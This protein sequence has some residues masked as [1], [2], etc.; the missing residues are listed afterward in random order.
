MPVHAVVL[1]AVHWT[2][3]FVVGLQ[4]GVGAS[5]LMSLAQGSHLPV[6]APVVMHTPPMHC[7]VVPHPGSPSSM[8]H[9]LPLGSHTLLAQTSA[10]A[11]AVHVPLSVGF[12]CAA[13]VGMAVP[14][15]RVGVHCPSDSSHQLPAPHSASV[16]QAL[17]HAPVVVLQ[18][19][20]GCVPV[21]H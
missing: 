9:T 13:S 17:V 10:A 18:N 3:V 7:A 16:V 2:H 1:V 4:A 20:P 5:Q 12:A 14:F 8:P 19:C 11:A 21:V 15:A 6:F